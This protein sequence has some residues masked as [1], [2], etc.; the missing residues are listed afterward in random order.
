MVSIRLNMNQDLLIAKD[1]L[2][3]IIGY[4]DNM[5]VYYVKENRLTFMGGISL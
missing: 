5:K 3:A 4:L 2:F 1:R